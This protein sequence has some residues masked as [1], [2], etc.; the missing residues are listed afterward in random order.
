MGIFDDF[1][2]HAPLI[3]PSVFPISQRATGQ[4]PLFSGFLAGRGVLADQEKVR[5]SEIDPGFGRPR[6]VARWEEA[7]PAKADGFGLSTSLGRP[8]RI[9]I[10]LQKL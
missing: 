1:S 10:G 3:I 4:K 5:R 6:E 9:D 7:I 8:R 2:V